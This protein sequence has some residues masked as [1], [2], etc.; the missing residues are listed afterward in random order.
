ML[1]EEDEE[2]SLELAH[3]DEDEGALYGRT[4]N[5]HQADFDLIRKWFQICEEFHCSECNRL[6][7]YPSTAPKIRLIDVLNRQITEK[8]YK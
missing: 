5:S 6:R 3:P 4:L 7:S 1:R 8:N 2:L